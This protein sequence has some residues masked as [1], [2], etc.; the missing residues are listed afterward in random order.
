[1]RALIIAELCN[2][3]W[4]S[5]PLE[6][7]SHYRALSKIAD[8]HLV[9]QIRN[10]AALLRAGLIEG[11]D[12]T[13]IDS[14]KVAKPIHWVGEKL[15][16]GKG[17]G[18]TTKMA[19]SALSQPYFERVLW[20]TFKQRLINKE[21]DVVHQLTPLSPTLPARTAA[22]CKR[23]GIPFC[24][25]PLNGGVAWPKDFDTARRDEK[26]WLTYVRNA[27]KLLP[28]F[29]RSRG[30]A[31]A[32]VIGSR[33]TWAQ[34][35]AKYYDKCVYIPE[36]AI[37]P[38]RFSKLRTRTATNPIRAIFVGRLVPYKGADM[39]LE[40]VE[41]L[42][43]AGK[44]VLDII[45]D[46]PQMQ[47]LKDRI[48]T[49]NIP[50]VTLHGFVK[51][52]ELQDK[53]IE[54]DVFT[55]PSIREFGGAVAL[56]AMAV[57]VP[58]IVPDYG[59]LGELVNNDTGWL[60]PMGSRASIIE[61]LRSILTDLSNNPEQIDT[62]APLAIQRAKTLFTWDAKAQQTMQVWNW[63]TGKASKPNNP[64]PL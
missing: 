18:W 61:K 13:A 60:I 45:G 14:E 29:S 56:E 9:T 58:A 49:N 5:V 7:W 62:K 42:A 17:K 40:A 33:D 28:G 26:E 23:I 20:N 55:F 63:V 50:G 2:P 31:S 16:G 34:M 15:R 53:L 44:V 1:M 51:H 24:W 21:F 6:G 43:K 35:P 46:G 41:P 32:I 36:N 11:K 48:A 57:G 39:L 64:M 59:G 10:R 3:E 22:R 37:D 19:L 54:A 12:F 47:L 38:E 4:V 8:V 52:T 25:G 27:Y 30:A